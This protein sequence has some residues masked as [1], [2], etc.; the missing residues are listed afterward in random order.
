M[1]LTIMSILIVCLRVV[2]ISAVAVAFGISLIGDWLARQ[3]PF[4]PGSP[5]YISGGI[6]VLIMVA[7]IGFRWNSSSVPRNL[8]L[9]AVGTFFHVPGA[10]QGSGAKWLNVAPSLTTDIPTQEP[11]FVVTFMVVIVTC[12]LGLIIDSAREEASDLL[13]RGLVEESVS[14]IVKQAAILKVGTLLVGLLVISVISFIPI[15]P[16]DSLPPAVLALVGVLVIIIP[17][18][19]YFDTWTSRNASEKEG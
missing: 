1:K 12:V 7:V 18:V 13:R 6:A 9:A 15:G 19:V 17:V 8:T 10:L 11:V 5:E 4:I 14:T 16:P 3:I 2:T